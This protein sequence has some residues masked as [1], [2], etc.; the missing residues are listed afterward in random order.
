MI[1]GENTQPHVAGDRSN[2]RRNVS[3]LHWKAKELNCTA[4][5]DPEKDQPP[6]EGVV[7][8]DSL[9]SGNFPAYLAWP[10]E[11]QCYWAKSVPAMRS[12][13]VSEN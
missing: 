4:V 5:G 10:F 2:D 1:G 8:L 7:A 12:C 6:P 3:R 9:F 13:M 11:R